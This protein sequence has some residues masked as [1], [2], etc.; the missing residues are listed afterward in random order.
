MVSIEVI[1]A[2][3]VAEWYGSIDSKQ[4]LASTGHLQMQLERGILEET[5]NCDGAALDCG[6][7]RAAA[8]RAELDRRTALAAAPIDAIGNFVEWDEVD[9][10]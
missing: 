5:R 2:E 10:F 8:L 4:K 1:K 6:A 3:A 7:S 9:I